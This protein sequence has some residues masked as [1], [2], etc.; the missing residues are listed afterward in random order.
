MSYSS[1]PSFGKMKKRGMYVAD[2]MQYNRAALMRAQAMGEEIVINPKPKQQPVPQAIRPLNPP[3]VTINNL[4]IVANNEEE[5]EKN[6][7]NDNEKEKVIKKEFEPKDDVKCI[8]VRHRQSWFIVKFKNCIEFYEFLDRF[9]IFG[10]F[11]EENGCL[12]ITHF[13]DLIGQ[14]VKYRTVKFN[15]FDKWAPSEIESESKDFKKF[16]STKNQI[17]SNKDKK[18]TKNEGKTIG[19]RHK[20]V[21]LQLTF[22]YE[23]EF[24][25]FLFDAKVYGLVDEHSALIV[26]TFDDLET[27]DYRMF[28]P[29]QFDKYND[30]YP[31]EMEKEKENSTKPSRKMKK[32]KQTNSS[33]SWFSL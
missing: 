8:Q 21:W 18:D 13:D 29:Q 7:D 2:T 30:G 24:E 33:S 4:N 28:N 22:R 10:L 6:N 15:E 31:K 12:I 26:R 3:T 11:A 23:W 5:E 27:S 9:C 25:K 19:I 16:H 20:F 14:N 17:G 32:Q 1:S